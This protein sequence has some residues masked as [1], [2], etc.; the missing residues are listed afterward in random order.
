MLFSNCV[1]PLITKPTRIKDFQQ[2]SCIDHIYT[3]NIDVSV[4]SGIMLYDIKDYHLPVFG[5]FDESFNI[6]KP[7][8]ILK[9]SFRKFKKDNFLNDVETELSNFITKNGQL[10][11]DDLYTKFAKKFTSALDRNA[12]IIRTS[13]REQRILMKPWLTPGLL[14]SI[15]NKQKM[16]VSHYLKGN[17]ED[18]LRYK[19]YSNIL[20]YVKERSKKSYLQQEFSKYKNNLK[21]TWNLINQICKIKKSK[22]SPPLQIVVNNVK[23][24]SPKEIAEHFNKYFRN[25]GPSLADKIPPTNAK[26]SDTLGDPLNFT[27]ALEPATEHEILKIISE[28]KPTKSCGTDNIDDQYS[29]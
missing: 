14:K 24:T 20:C 25:V 23:V 4:T 2:P 11:T 8:K 7:P 9:R 13:I 16:Y 12:P 28:L 15:K 18:R 21:A 19:K 17:E 10:P 6:A 29:S 27:L 26:F 3:S 5:I 1:S 22:S